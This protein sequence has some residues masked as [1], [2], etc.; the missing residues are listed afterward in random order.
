MAHTV[1]VV[2]DDATVREMLTLCFQSEG[3][4]VIAFSSGSGVLEELQRTSVDLIIMDILMGK[5][6]GIET[7][8]SIRNSGL[9]VPVIMISGD[10]KYLSYSMF[11]GA[12]RLVSKPI[13]C[14]EIIKLVEE[15]I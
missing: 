12:T 11:A 3:Y 6:N 7:L 1:M 10:D 8:E 14:N 9:K 13:D 15:L 2:D 5:D 4:D